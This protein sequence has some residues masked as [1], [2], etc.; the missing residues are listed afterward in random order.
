M[1]ASFGTDGIRGV[2]GI[3]LTP[4]LATDVGRAAGALLPG[5]RWLIGSD[6]RA[7]GPM[8][9]AALAAGLAS[10]GKDVEDLGVL[11][12][13]AVAYLSQR[14]KVPA[15]V[16]SASH[17][18]WTDNGIKLLA[19]GGRKL[20]DEA[21]VAIAA[22]MGR[23][24]TT[25]PG[26]IRHHDDPTSGYAEHLV[27][28]LEG[29]RLDG[30][31]V[32]VDCANGA[33]SAVAPQV[34]RSLGAEL[35]V[36]CAD[37]DGTNINA[38]CGSTHPELLQATVVSEGAAAGL[39]FDGD[40]DRV[41]AVDENGALVDG[42]HIIAMCAADL[43]R[44]GRL[45]GDAVAVT[46]MSNLGLRLALDAAGIGV[47]ETPV[48]DRYVLDAMAQADLALGGEQS[49]HVIFADLA[50][51]GDG[52]LTGLQV[53]DVVARAG[54]ALSGLA[55]EAMTHLPQVL[56]N[57][58]VSDR[59]ALD[60]ASELWALVADIDAELDGRGRVLLRPSGTEPLVRVMVEAP[61]H[62]EASGIA[63]RLASAVAAALG[64]EP[65][66]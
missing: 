39:A 8:L 53:L 24:P 13:P 30:M 2:A 57:V 51:T 3:D 41:I 29:R 45:R 42:D 18:P 36:L 28:S 1:P 22:L 49:G 16:V 64:S 63:D 47:V 59:D 46:V 33:A 11:P 58:R 38:G 56:R 26:S 25:A 7:S 15:A 20:G 21:E 4:E 14:D 44:R 55:R 9:V 5:D 10:A 17:N 27:S 61:S 52:V 50:T 12:T 65:R 60:E 19:A 66:K 23:A 62:A 37:P 34:L 31:H 32:V 6:G 48:G 35:V 54:R 40:A 43:R